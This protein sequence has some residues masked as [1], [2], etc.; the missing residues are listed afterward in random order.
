[1]FPWHPNSQNWLFQAH[2]LPP[3][4]LSLSMKRFILTKT[5]ATS[6]FFFPVFS[7]SLAGVI[8]REDLK[9]EFN[10]TRRTFLDYKGP[11]SLQESSGLWENC[12]KLDVPQ[13]LHCIWSQE[14][15][16]DGLKKSSDLLWQCRSRARTI[17]S[18]F[19]MNEHLLTWKQQ[20]QGKKKKRI[21]P[22]C[23]W[24]AKSNSGGSEFSPPVAGLKGHQ[25]QP[26]WPV[27]GAEKGTITSLL[28]S[29]QGGT[30][31]LQKKS[32]ASLFC[33]ILQIGLSK[34]WWVR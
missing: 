16:Y 25:S 7:A 28:A 9:D 10:E 4:G 6:R 21:N 15:V 14:M 29:I 23:H 18:F 22:T 34:W 30:D 17:D 1:M 12:P 2:P 33:C 26:A 19:R 20:H 8:W 27:G 32:A 3:W 31:W 5:W 11:A 24:S 13:N